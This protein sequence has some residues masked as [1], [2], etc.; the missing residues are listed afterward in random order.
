M[1]IILQFAIAV[2]L[3][4]PLTSWPQEQGVIMAPATVPVAPEITQAV[5]GFLTDNPP[6]SAQVYAIT[7]LSL[8]GNGHVVSVVGLE[9]VTAPDYAWSLEDGNQAIWSGSVIVEDGSARLFE[10]ENGACHD[11]SLNLAGGGADVRFPFAGKMMYGLRGV[12]GSGDYGTTGM[13]A[14]DWVGGD[15]MGVGVASA[16]VY[17]SYDGTIDYTC[18]DGTSQAIRVTDGG[19]NVFVYA[20]LVIDSGL[21]VGKTFARGAHIGQLVYGSFND[22]CGWASQKDNHYHV[23]WMFKPS[24]GYYQAEGWVLNVSGG[25][26]ASGSSSI[27]VNEWMTSGQTTG[28]DN[29]DDATTTLGMDKNGHLSGIGGQHVWDFIVAG[30]YNLVNQLASKILPEH[31]AEPLYD[32]NGNPI[33]DQN[34]N[35]VMRSSNWLNGLM[36]AM[37][38]AILTANQILPGWVNLTITFVVLGTFF[39]SESIYLIYALW[40]FVLKIIPMMQ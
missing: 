12:H 22:T 8:Y 5:Q 39:V 33:V 36:I 21:T 23:H 6:S 15:D 24:N 38:D 19:D 14:V 35:A 40:R 1:K 29:E 4:N 37:R 30:V 3:L 2:S 27:G 18:D 11:C 16:D 9:N 20:H 10:V 13:L 26:W 7:S 32:A 17:A 28:T 25:K 34:G 31:Q